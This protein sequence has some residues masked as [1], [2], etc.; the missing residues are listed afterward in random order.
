MKKAPTLMARRRFVSSA[1]ASA[2]LA[3]LPVL[4]ARLAWAAPA[5]TPDAPRLVLVLLRG[6]LDGLAAVPA[7]GDPDFAAARGPLGVFSEPAL[8]LEGPF[9]LHPALAQ[10]VQTAATLDD[11][12][13]GSATTQFA[14]ICARHE[15]QYSRLYRS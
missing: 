12:A 15:L 14:L 11:E 9:A 6:G 13:L 8:P 1:L 2:G 3:A 5:P 10:A 7:P 4:P